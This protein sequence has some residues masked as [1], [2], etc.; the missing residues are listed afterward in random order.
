MGLS[1]TRLVAGAITVG[2]LSL[3]LGGPTVA[4]KVPAKQ[5]VINAV[6]ATESATSLTLVGAIAQGKQ[7]VSLKVTASNAGDGQG[8]IG[9]GKAVATVRWVGG[10]VY[11]WARARSG[12]NRV[13][14]RLRSASRASR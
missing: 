6:S 14:S 11:L 5:M 7:T 10:T 2:A 1:P 4:A 3:A 13:G 9:I 8:T 12:P